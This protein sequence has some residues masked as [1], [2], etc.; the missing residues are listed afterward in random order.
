MDDGVA[1]SSNDKAPVDIRNIHLKQYRTCPREDDD[2]YIQL[3]YYAM[4][5]MSRKSDE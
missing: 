5:Y 2:I 1:S 4:E 3:H